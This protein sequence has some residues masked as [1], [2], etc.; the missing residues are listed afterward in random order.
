MNYR[1][2]L[3]IKYSI[4]KY[5]L[6]VLIIVICLLLFIGNKKMLDI[7]NTIGY[8]KD[9]TLVADIPISSSM[10]ISSMKYIKVN[11]DYY[12]L[13]DLSI[14]DILLDE[15]NLVNYQE[16]II[17]LKDNINNHML[18]P[19][20]IYYNEEKVFEKIRKIVF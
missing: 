6:I 3:N 2:L 10:S 14:S 20:T 5:I 17:Q 13:N 8:V 16:V 7:Y 4:K 11:N 9:D 12:Y 19:I 18:V 1:D 15:N